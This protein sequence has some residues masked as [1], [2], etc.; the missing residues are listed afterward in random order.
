MPPGDILYPNTPTIAKTHRRMARPGRGVDVKTYQV[1]IV[2]KD[3]L[4]PPRPMIGNK[5][6]L[7][8]IIREL[9]IGDRVTVERIL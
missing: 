1:V 8:P 9:E 3:E 7:E 2:K 4:G 6:D 5:A